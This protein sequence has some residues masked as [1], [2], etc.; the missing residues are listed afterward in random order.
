MCFVPEQ[1]AHPFWPLHS[2][3][4]S[5]VWPFP[6]QTMHVSVVVVLLGMVAVVWF[7]M[8]RQMKTEALEWEDGCWAGGL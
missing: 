6:L 4:T 3:H 7:L 2:L 5:M 1:K 8:E